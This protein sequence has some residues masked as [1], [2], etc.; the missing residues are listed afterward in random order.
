MKRQVALTLFSVLLNINYAFALVPKPTRT[1]PITPL[2]YFIKGYIR[3]L[4][5]TGVFLGMS[6][7]LIIKRLKNSNKKCSKAFWISYILFAIISAVIIIEYCYQLIEGYSIGHLSALAIVIMTFPLIYLIKF[8]I[9]KRKNNSPKLHTFHK[10][11]LLISSI[12]LVV[13]LGFRV[14]NSIDIRIKIKEH[15]TSNESFD[16]GIIIGDIKKLSRG[17]SDLKAK[18]RVGSVGV[19]DYDRLVTKYTIIKYDDSVKVK[20]HGAIVYKIPSYNFDSIHFCD[21]NY[22]GFG[23]LWHYFRYSFMW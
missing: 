15:L 4:W 16:F 6:I 9:D 19:Y 10:V 3:L 7:F 12:L 22:Y 21:E 20:I 5:P 18:Q 17:E 14:Y 11:I 23:E 1:Q 2:S 13:H 8:L